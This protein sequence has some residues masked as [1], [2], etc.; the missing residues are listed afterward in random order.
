MTLLKSPVF[1]LSYLVW[2]ELNGLSCYILEVV[3]YHIIVQSCCTSKKKDK[4]KLF[5]Y[6]NPT[7][8]HPQI[9]HGI[10]G[11]SNELYDFF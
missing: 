8:F 11:I 4:Q 6:R 9:V 5:S 3:Y 1:L 10:V 7:D 2:K